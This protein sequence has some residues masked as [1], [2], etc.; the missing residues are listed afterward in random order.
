MHVVDRLQFL[1]HPRFAE[2]GFKLGAG[3]FHVNAIKPLYQAVEESIG[4]REVT[5]H[6]ALE[7]LGLAY[8]EHS[9]L[10]IAKGVDAGKRG[11]KPYLRLQCRAVGGQAFPLA[12]LQPRQ[13]RLHA[14]AVLGGNPVEQS[15]KALCGHARVDE[16]SVFWR[17]V[18]TEMSRQAFQAWPL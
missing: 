11:K 18:Q 14:C 5:A 12:V 8:I 13:E 16:G 2:Q 17:I 9:A 3:D 15:R 7:R 10:A 1:D 6:P 4:I